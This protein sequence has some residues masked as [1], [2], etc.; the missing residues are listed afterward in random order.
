MHSLGKR[1]A[2]L[3]RVSVWPACVCDQDMPTRHDTRTGRASPA[4]VA[5][6]NLSTIGRGAVGVG[7]YISRVAVRKFTVSVADSSRLVFRLVFFFKVFFLTACNLQ[8]FP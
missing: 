2:L 1:T 4:H 5:R 8:F 3:D 6:N 7:T